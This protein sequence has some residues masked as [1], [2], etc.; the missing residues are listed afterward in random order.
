MC[1]KTIYEELPLSDYTQK[2]ILQHSAIRKTT[3]AIRRAEKVKLSWPVSDY[4]F[5]PDRSIR[6][7]GSCNQFVHVMVK[8][9]ND[10]SHSRVTRGDGKPRLG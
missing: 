4:F 8:V 2:M 10:F 7:C 5:Y 6:N 1:G 9:G 3:Y